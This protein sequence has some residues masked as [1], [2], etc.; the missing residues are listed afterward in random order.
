MRASSP[1]PHRR[2]LELSDN[3][4]KGRYKPLGLRD[5]WGAT[6]SDDRAVGCVLWR[7]GRYL[8]H[9]ERRVTGDEATGTEAAIDFGQAFADVIRDEAA[10]LSTFATNLEPQRAAIEAACARLLALRRPGSP[11]RVVVSGIGKAGLVG[12]KIAATLSSTGTPSSF[13]HPVEGL[14]GDLGFVQPHDCGLLL[15]FSGETVELLRL[16]AQ[17]SAAGCGLIAITRSNANSLG[18]MADAC[19]ET[20]ALREACYMGLAPSSSTTIMMAIGDALALATASAAGFAAEDFNRFHPGGT[21][22]LRFTRLDRLMRTDERL[23]VV[24]QETS[25][26]ET[27]VRITAAKTGAAVVAGPNRELLGI[28]TDGDLRRTILLGQE[29]MAESI[30]E[31]CTHPCLSIDSEESVAA[32]LEVFQNSP[33]EELPVVDSQTSQVVGLLCL[34]DIPSF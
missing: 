1:D 22:G 2:P 26:H 30:W 7:T 11:G 14:H 20:G 24:E 28:F 23:V 5:R 12:R 27:I 8:G 32:A 17:L 33:I 13:I 9:E 18:Q 16:G 21:L 29:V 3:G 4:L 34:R 10:A 6:W 15:S 19:I 31:F 25:L